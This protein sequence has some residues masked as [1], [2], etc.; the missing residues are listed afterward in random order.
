MQ[1]RWCV[2]NALEL[3]SGEGLKILNT[4]TAVSLLGQVYQGTLRAKSEESY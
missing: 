2:M 3:K 4:R 1:I